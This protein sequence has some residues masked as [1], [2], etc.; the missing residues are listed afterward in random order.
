MQ[1]PIQ[2]LNFFFSHARWHGFWRESQQASSV[3]M[4]SH[5][6]QMMS[7]SLCVHFQKPMQI[8]F[9]V[10]HNVTN[11]KTR[12]E[13][14]LSDSRF[15]NSRCLIL[16][17]QK[18]F[19]KTWHDEYYVEMILWDKIFLFVIFFFSLLTLMRQNAA[20]CRLLE[21]TQS[22]RKSWRVYEKTLLVTKY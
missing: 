11:H 1:E 7:V 19:A 17:L 15:I 18:Q 6:L 13:V 12:Q 3:L 20:S 14:I 21:K 16:R 5:Q 9:I 10:L 22:F 8:G 4:I 2:K